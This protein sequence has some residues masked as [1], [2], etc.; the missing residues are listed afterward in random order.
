MTKLMRMALPVSRRRVLSGSMAAPALLGG[1]SGRT[2]TAQAAGTV[3]FVGWSAAV[4]Q[5]RAHI[6]AFER[7]TNIRVN[8]E[9]FPWAQYRTALVTRL[10]GNAPIDV[11]WVSDAWL[12]EFAEAGWLAEIN[13]IPQLMRYNAEAAEYCT[14]SMIYRGKQYGLAYYGDHMSFMYNTELLQRAGIAAPPTTW[15]EVVEQSQRIK[16]QGIS[17]FP[18]LLSLAADTWLIEF[19]TAL[20]Y[21]FGGRMVDEQGNAAMADT[22]RGAVR[23]AQFLRDAIHQHRIV[24]PGAVETPEINGLRAIGS[25]AHAFGIVPTYRIRALNDPS[26]AQAAG[27]IR[28]ALMPKGGPDGTNATCGWIRFYGMTPGAK[29]DRTRRERAVRFMEFFGGRDTSGTYSM[30]RLLLTDVGLPSC[31]L[32]LAQDPAVQEF[33][34]RWAG[35]GAIIAQQAN[36]A[37]KKDTISPWFGEWV[38][39][40]N[41]SWQAVCL[42]R[43][44]PE[45]AMRSAAAKWTELRRAFR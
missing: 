22:G 11:S 41:Q 31:A 23:A 43:A 24:S 21:A 5:V 2:A 1:F 7:A 30:Q 44:A 14:Q 16:Q 6:S 39:T 18:L 27:K 28:I 35:G 42:G 38:E 20:T 19:V 26:Q 8:Y 25:G 32:P 12:P 15:E 33:W 34:E 10:V 29:A 3:N 17:E 45:A 36:L 37:R 4:D 9:N 13:D 40:A